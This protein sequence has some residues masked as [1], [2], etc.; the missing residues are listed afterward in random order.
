MTRMMIS[1][2][3]GKLVNIIYKFYYP[4]ILFKAKNVTQIPKQK[5]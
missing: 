4:E 1:F 2:I 3:S 5:S